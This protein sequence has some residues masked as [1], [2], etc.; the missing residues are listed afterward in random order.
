MSKRETIARYSLI[1]KKLRKFPA[2]FD[3]IYGYLELESELQSYNFMISKRTFQRDLEDI[4]SLYNIDICFNFSKKVY[5]IDDAGQPDFQDRMLE[6]FDVFNTLNMAENMASYIYLE[7][8]KPQR[9]ENIHGLLHAIKNK[10]QIKFAYEKFWEEKI[11]LRTAEPYFLKEI[12]NRWYVLAKDLKD[13]T[14]K[15]FALDR[16]SNLEISH[17]KFKIDTDYNPEKHFE[18][19]FGIIS[20]NSEKPDKIV[21]SFQPFQ[22]K[23]IKTLPLHSSQKILID[24]DK[25]LRI[26]LKLYITHDFLM[27]LLSFGIEMKVIEPKHL[28]EDIKKTFQK[29]LENYG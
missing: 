2:T 26:E 21:L 9:T 25:E 27:E 22:G 6:A 23:Y 15:S 16:L 20:P 1:I 11:T 13:N 3:E 18:N 17:I 5:Y 12:K 24:S 28:V 14:I 10:F 7:K 29:A 4:R 8:R 19:S